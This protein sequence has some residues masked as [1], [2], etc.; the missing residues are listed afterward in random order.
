MMTTQSSGRTAFA[1]R[2]VFVAAVAAVVAPPPQLVL[3]QAAG[4]DA[5]TFTVVR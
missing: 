3:A 4:D 1:L 5:V 2:A